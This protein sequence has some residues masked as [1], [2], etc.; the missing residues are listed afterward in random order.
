MRIFVSFAIAACVATAAADDLARFQGVWEMTGTSRG[1]PFRVV[2]T[3]VGATET[4]EVYFDSELTQKHHVDFE[5]HSHGPARV[6]VWKNGRITAGPRAGQ[7]LPDGRCIY[8]MHGDTLTCVHGMLDGDRKPFLRE[9][10][11]RVGAQP[12]VNASE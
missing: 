2:K 11:R 10:Y 5:L 3:I 9:V 7:A 12:A 8:R 4:V 1:K 6:F